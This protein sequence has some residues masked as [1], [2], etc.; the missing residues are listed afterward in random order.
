MYFYVDREKIEKR[1]TNKKCNIPV[2]T[3]SLYFLHRN[4]AEGGDSKGEGTPERT[5]GKQEKQNGGTDWKH[6]EYNRRRG[7]NVQG[8]KNGKGKNKIKER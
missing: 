6:M 1:L 4:F 8:M 5:D 3:F 2:K 7:K